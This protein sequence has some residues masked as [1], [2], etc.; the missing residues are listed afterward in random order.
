LLE[1]Y[2][3]ALERRADWS[4]LNKTLIGGLALAAIRGER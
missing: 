1:R 4:H 3:V 2:L